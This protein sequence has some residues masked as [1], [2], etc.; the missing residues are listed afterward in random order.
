MTVAILIAVCYIHPRL[1]R[2]MNLPAQSS[3]L[4]LLASIQTVAEFQQTNIIFAN[5]VNKMASGVD[6]SKSKFIVIFIV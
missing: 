2:R 3:A 5:L 1:D 6:L 4:Q